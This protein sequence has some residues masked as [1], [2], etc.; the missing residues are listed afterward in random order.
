M[1]MNIYITKVNRQNEFN[2]LVKKC[3]DFTINYQNRF[4]LIVR[5]WLNQDK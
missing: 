3:Q 2:E 1:I 5:S 4:N